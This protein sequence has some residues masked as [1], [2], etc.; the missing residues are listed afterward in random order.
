LILPRTVS[1]L[2]VTKC[3][4]DSLGYTLDEVEG[5]H[6]SIFFNESMYKAIDMLNFGTKKHVVNLSLEKMSARL[7]YR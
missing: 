2:A 4:L 7:T 6:H 5:K 1:L 3:F